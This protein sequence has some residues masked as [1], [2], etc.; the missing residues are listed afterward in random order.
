M[1]RPPIW[2]LI[3]GIAFI[4]LGAGQLVDVV[5]GKAGAVEIGFAVGW[6]VIGGWWIALYLK[7]RNQYLR[8][9]T[10]DGPTR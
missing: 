6:A 1:S 8:E 4:V 3:A 9:A 7:R 5:A 10:D 2:Q